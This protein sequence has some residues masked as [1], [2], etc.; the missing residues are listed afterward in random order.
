MQGL[1]VSVCL[2]RYQTQMRRFELVSH[3]FPWWLTIGQ[4]TTELLSEL[5][6][7]AAINYPAIQHNR[8]AKI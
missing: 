2:S 8:V 1:F 5:A 3:R 7:M 6:S 4:P